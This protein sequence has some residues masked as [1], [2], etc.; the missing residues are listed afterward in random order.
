MG[1]PA[2]W[3]DETQTVESILTVIEKPLPALLTGRLWGL[4]F[5]S[6]WAAREFHEYL[7]YPVR[8]AH[9]MGPAAQRYAPGTWGSVSNTHTPPYLQQDLQGF[10][11]LF[12]WFNSYQDSSYASHL[13]I[14]ATG[15][16]DGA[17]SRSILPWIWRNGSDRQC[18]QIFRLGFSLTP[19]STS[20]TLHLSSPV[21]HF[22]GSGSHLVLVVD[23]PDN[24]R[25]TAAYH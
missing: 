13:A 21:Y 1:G 12:A 10:R 14:S 8:G 2:G 19:R 11:S 22:F 6:L 15:S 16:W 18:H 23:S 4:P 17:I 3:A 20:W 25:T 5:P 9:S 24:R 7:R